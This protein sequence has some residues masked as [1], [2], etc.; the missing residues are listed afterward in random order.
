MSLSGMVHKSGEPLK[1]FV[2]LFNTAEIEV[3]NSE[4]RMVLMALV[5]AINKE[6][7]FGKWV[8]MKEPNTIEKFYKKA[9]EFLKWEE[10][11]VIDGNV[12]DTV[13]NNP[14]NNP[15]EERSCS[16]RREKV[17]R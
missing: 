6:T 7:K 10:A 8:K 5:W 1:S 15:K 13:K 4:S 12:V 14:V 16:G 11:S 17:G 2:N 3:G 9:D